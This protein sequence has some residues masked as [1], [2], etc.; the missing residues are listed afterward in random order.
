[1]ISSKRACPIH[2]H[3]APEL[4]PR[5]FSFN[6]P[7]GQC[8]HCLGLGYVEEFDFEAMFNP[9]A[10]IKEAFIP[11]GEDKRLPFSHLDQHMWPLLLEQIEVDG[12]KTW[13]D[14]TNREKG[15]LLAGK[16]V[17][18]TVQTLDG[19]IITKKRWK[20]LEHICRMTL[21]YAPNTRLSKYRSKRVCTVCNGKR[22]NPV[23]LAVRFQN[24]N[25]HQF[26]TEDIG[27]LHA[28]FSTL[29]WASIS[30]SSVDQSPSA[31]TPAGIPCTSWIEL[32]LPGSFSN[33][34]IRW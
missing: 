31:T 2:G 15:F 33:N 8:G 11:F 34:P 20:G 16:G 17:P 21:K 27:S 28:F 30:N 4:E 18:Y 1:M 23:A 10:E 9:S 24:K 19:R 6:D 7:Q 22:L 26:S 13:L 32:P 3:T 14:L 5:L 12:N 29:N 25:I